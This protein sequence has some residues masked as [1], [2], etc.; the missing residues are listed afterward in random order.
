MKTAIAIDPGGTT[1]FAIGKAN[2]EVFGVT[3]FQEPY[4][5]EGLYAYLRSVGFMTIICEDFLYRNA[6]RPGLEL[7]SR[8]M[9]GVIKLYCQQNKIK[10]IMQNPG[11]AVGKNAYFSNDRLKKMGVYVPGRPHAMDALRHLLHWWQFGSGFQ[12]NARQR[13]ELWP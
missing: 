12:Y 2:N 4:S 5:H 8:E 3:P 11:E 7:V 1:G 10:P 6:A 9:I 13:I